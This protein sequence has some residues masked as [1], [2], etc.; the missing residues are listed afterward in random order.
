MSV[1]F[2]KSRSVWKALK[3][4]LYCTF[5]MP[6]TTIM[7]MWNKCFLTDHSSL[8]NLSWG[9]TAYK[10]IIIIML[11]KPTVSLVCGRLMQRKMLPIYAAFFN[12]KIDRLPKARCCK[13]A[14]IFLLVLPSWALL[15]LKMLES[16]W[17]ERSLANYLCKILLHR[18]SHLFFELNF[19]AYEENVFFVR[20]IFFVYKFKKQQMFLKTVRNIGHLL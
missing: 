7:L 5:P 10:C 19:I 2:R 4:D 17:D 8:W 3:W 18:P 13:L 20:K 9:N 6:H 16:Y 11:L 14:G 12:F 1:N 15:C